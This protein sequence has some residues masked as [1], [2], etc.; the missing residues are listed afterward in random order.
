MIEAYALFNGSQLFELKQVKS[1]CSEKY[2]RPPEWR[3]NLAL[4]ST[5]CTICALLLEHSL[6]TFLQRRAAALPL[7]L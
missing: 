4:G 5:L 2:G 7:A 3:Y 1:A 6:A